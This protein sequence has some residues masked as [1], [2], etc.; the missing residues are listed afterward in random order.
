MNPYGDVKFYPIHD[1]EPIES[2]LFRSDENWG[3]L[4]TL[5]NRAWREKNFLK[6][7]RL[8][9]NQLPIIEAAECTFVKK[10]PD[11]RRTEV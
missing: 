1:D 4:K 5:I 7:C 8:T 9:E 11:A 6:R 2:S 3:G 10:D